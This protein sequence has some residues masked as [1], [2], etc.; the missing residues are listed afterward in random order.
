MLLVINLETRTDRRRFMDR[1]CVGPLRGIKTSVE[2]VPAI[3]AEDAVSD[4]A[5]PAFEL[6][7]DEIPALLDA[8]HA[9]GGEAVARSGLER[10]YA[11]PVSAA[12]KACTKS[13]RKAWVR[14]RAAFQAQADLPWVLIVEDDC[15]PCLHPA[16]ESQWGA[17]YGPAWQVAWRHVSK[18]MARCEGFDLVYVG[19]HRL[20]CPEVS[21]DVVRP[22]NFSSCLH[23][24]CVTRR[25]VER[26]LAKAEGLPALPADDLVPAL[27][28]AHPRKNLVDA[29]DP[30]RAGCLPQDV[31]FQLKFIACPGD[32]VRSRVEQYAF[33]AAARRRGG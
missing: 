5:H 10:Y 22:A 20:G 24:Y 25:G 11:R 3:A 7:K 23:A 6:R 4:R 8:W 33:D 19:R 32:D 13:H 30:L 21:D 1:S 2:Y 14:A 31:L 18:S 26:L 17:F 9:P 28:G 29:E 16:C 15:V 12:E 27:C